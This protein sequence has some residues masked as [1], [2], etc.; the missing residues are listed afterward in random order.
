MDQLSDRLARL[1]P[2][3]LAELMQRLRATEAARPADAAIPRRSGT[4]PSPLSFSQQRLWFIQQLDPANT[5]Y[6]MVGATH[7]VGALDVDALERAVDVVVQRHEAL[8]T[9]FVQEDGE[10]VQQVVAGMRVPVAAKDLCTVP[11]DASDAEVQRHARREQARPFDLAR[12]PLLR[13]TLLRLAPERHVLVLGIH[14]I[15][16][17]GWSRGIIVH[18]IT[19]ACAA[20]L[21]GETPRLA[22]LPIQYPDYA[23]W[24]RERL[25][26]EVLEQQLGYWRKKLAGAPAALELPADH[27]RPVVQSFAGRTH[28]FRLPAATVEAL[29][30]VGRQHDATLFIVLLAAYKTLLARYSGQADLVVGTPVA[31][32]TRGETQGLIGFFANTLALRTDLSGDPT[33]VDVLRRVRETALG[34]YAHEE[35]PFDRVVEELQP[36]R[37]LSRSVVFQTMFLLEE[38]R[39]RP[40]RMGPVEL[41]PVDVDT[42]TSM[43]DLTL[44]IEQDDDGF[45][46]R[47]E[48]ATALFDAPTIERMAEH[49][50]VLLRG[51]AADPGAPISR[52]RLMGAGEQARIDGWN[53]TDHG[54]PADSRVHELFA[55]Q[56]ARTPDAPAVVFRGEATSYAELD[57]RSNRLANHLRALGAGVETRVGVCLDRTPELVVS[58]LA[59]LK[60]GGAYVPLDPAYPRERLGYMTQDAGV[61]LVITTDALGDRLPSGVEAVRIDADADRIASE[62]PDAPHV[63]VDAENL[64]HVIFTSG[65]T[66]RPKGVMIRHSSTAILLHWMRENVSDGERAAVLGSTSVNFDVSVA[67]IFGALCWGGKLVLVENALEL[68]EVADQEIRYASMVPT[69]AAELLRAGGIPASV[70]TIN[71][72]GEALPNDLAQALYATGTVEKVGNLYGPT[73]DTSYSTYSMVERGAERVLIGRPL[74]S[75]AALVLDAQLQSVPVG[76]AGELYL[77]GGGL[78]RGYIGSPALTAERFVPNPFGAPGA[79][80]YRAMDRVRWTASGELEYFGRTDFQ[81]KVRGFRIELGEIETA[82]RAHPSVADAVAIVRED[83]SGDRRLVAYLIAQAGAEV[84][85]TAGLRAYLRERLPEYM[86]PSAF[87]PLDALPLTPSGKADR[88]A[89]PAPDASAAAAHAYVAPRTP[90]EARLA[91][92]FAEVLGVERVGVHDG[93]FDAGGHSLLVV[94]VVTRLRAALGVE[95]PVRAMFE[96]PSV[97]ELAARVDALLREGATDQAPPLVP[98]PRDRPLP[99]SFAQQRLWFIQQLD[100]ANVAYN[101]LGV[102]R[103]DGV[104]DAAALQRALGTVVE[105]HEALRTVFVQQGGEPVQQVVAGMRVTLELEDVQGVDR[106]E[107]DAEVE[108][109]ARATQGRPFDLAA[110]PLLRAS[111][112]RLAPESHVLVLVMHHVISDGWSRGVIVGELSAA[113]TAV[114]NGQVPRLP[115]LPVQYPDYAAWQRE[116][117][118]GPFLSAQLDYW[119]GA[120][121]GAPPVLALPTDHPRPPLQSFAGRGHAFRLPDG[122]ADALQTIAREEGATLFMVCLAAFKTLLARYTGRADLVVGTPVANRARGETEGLIGFFANMLALRTDLSGDPTFREILRRVRETALG[123][124]AHE[125]VP[126]ERLVEELEIERSLSRNPVFQVVFLLDESPVS[127]MRLPRLELSPVPVELETSIFDLTLALSR[128]GGGLVGRLEYA[129]ALF[130]ASTAQRMTEH[131]TVLLRGIAADPDARLSHLPM[132]S[133]A[134]RAHLERWNATDRGYPAGVLVHDLFAAQAART[135]DAPALVFRGETTTYAEL[136]ARANRLANHLRGLGVGV[137]TRVGVCLERTPELI[138]SLLAVHKAGGAYVPLDPAYPRERLGYMTADAGV[139]LVITSS[140]LAPRLPVGVEPVCLD[141]VAH[142]IASASPQAPRVRVDPENLSHVIFTSGST[143]RPKGVMIRHS[144]TAV[145]VHWMRENVSDDERAAVLGST[146]INFDV[147]VAEIFGTLCWGGKLVVVENA[148]ELPAVADQ[149]IRYASMVPTAAAELLRSGGIPASVRTLNLGGE[150]LPNELAQALYAL[151]TVDR[152]GNLYGP[153][154]DTTYSTYAVVPRGADRVLVG[155]PV[156][157]TAAHVLDAE[158]RPVAVGIIGELY[159]AGDGLARGYAGRPGLTAE[160]FLPNPFGPAGSRMYRVMD[161]VRWTALGELEYFGRTDH[162]V[163]VRG[164]RIE[165]GEIESALALHPSVGES[166]VTTWDDGTGELRLVAY[167]TSPAEGPA[168]SPPE[169]RRWVGERLPPYMVPSLFIPLDALPLTPNGKTDRRALPEPGAARPELEEEYAPPRNELE[170]TI[171]EVWREVLGVERVGIRD[172]F[173]E[174]GGTSVR[175]ASVQRLLADRLQ[176][177]VTIVDLFQYPTVADLAE[178]LAEEEDDDGARRRGEVHD[179]AGRQRQAR[180]TRQ[181]RGRENR[182]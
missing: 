176:R 76:I 82:L 153:T 81:V 6:N 119:R 46:A 86:V 68:P 182:R 41:V 137:E 87:V 78:A 175:L 117:L 64:S 16:S 84:P 108:R 71:L 69:A 165:L 106:E 61:R 3:R 120:L 47:L 126:F 131:L 130:D 54:Y 114:V 149:E 18:E 113:Y 12:G 112:L 155:A 10:P 118:Q 124:W 110:G 37:S 129:T 2:E 160:R 135:P 180:A 42:G 13:V 43:L 7:L 138:V 48:Y 56:A 136:D 98:V 132:L 151:E 145:L 127:T 100:P 147:S 58:L 73:E 94:R 35:L 62:S 11:P 44:G 143:G 32:R 53:A 50:A 27:P 40:S 60:A 166:V 179:R 107:V 97:A 9:V 167:V 93:F 4:G 164:F 152:V 142:H 45:V 109:R 14:H 65:S 52:L 19:A 103:L 5:A 51:I 17:D 156:A 49:L 20:L 121:A 23:V 89:L 80:M 161:R 83:V 115:H 168:A 133:D 1:S 173:F 169:L 15:I 101:I 36:A 72:A 171:S 88:R 79:R 140:T 55:A 70:R 148:L 21:A 66:G 67:E 63:R 92:I 104:L 122:I 91:G 141:A 85:G 39:P 74:A 22:E 170:G 31:N 139:H 99:L 30:A 134:D 38:S 25:R 125:E 181:A 59:V 96:A 154:E 33:F 163:K 157:N 90:T 146:S 77:A 172:N 34:A 57:A 75:T 159:L 26:G 128:D 158:L 95:V 123:A 29:R 150:A 111:L 144:S 24:Q 177:E 178:C 28:R 162:Q 105:R 116:R 174:L 102:I 8:R